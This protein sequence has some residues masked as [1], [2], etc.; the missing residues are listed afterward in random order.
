M[1][2]SGPILTIIVILG[3]TGIM[4]FAGQKINLPTPGAPTP[5]NVN[6]QSPFSM[7][8]SPNV[9]AQELCYIWNTEAGDRAMLSMDIRGEKVIGEFHF[10]PAEKDSKVGIFKGMV[11]ALNIDPE[12]HSVDAI[13]DAKAEGTVVEEQL[14]IVFDKSIASAGFGEMKDRGDGVYVYAD[15]TKISYSPNMQR[16]DCGDNAMD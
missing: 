2:I 10:L 15:P 1:K 5:N 7:D 14:W 8:L 12:K 3:I 13:W 4:F 11:S 16:T 9:N 6:Q